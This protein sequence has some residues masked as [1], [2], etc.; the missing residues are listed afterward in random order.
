MSELPVKTIKPG[1]L[2][3]NDSP[4]RIKTLLGSCVSVTVHNS[5][6]QFGGM[7]HFMLPEALPS[8][9]KGPRDF[10]FGDLSVR[11]M[12]D[13]MLTY[14]PNPDH[15]DVKIFGGGRVVSALSHANIGKNNV[16]AAIEVLEEY[17]LTPSEKH[18]EGDNGL[19]LDFNTQSNE[20]QVERIRR[21]DDE[22][23]VASER[24]EEQLSES[25]GRI[26]DILSGSSGDEGIDFLS[27]NE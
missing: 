13:R 24:E 4:C 26:E 3:V 7:N 6:K 2:Y 17:D 9:Q 25:E 23:D 20:V 18:V 12:I 14:D 11:H 1:E 21:T 27:Q 16:Q 22:Y 15:L 8:R 19:K 5:H 10:R